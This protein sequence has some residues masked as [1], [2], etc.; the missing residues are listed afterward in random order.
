MSVVQL[1]KT[2]NR[3]PELRLCFSFELFSLL[4]RSSP[5]SSPTIF[6]SPHNHIRRH[7]HLLRRRHLCWR[8]LLY[9]C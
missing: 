2:S 1:S 9:C 7:H 6:Q 5:P 4:T 8:L 3:T